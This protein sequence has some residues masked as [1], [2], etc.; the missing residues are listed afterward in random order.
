VEAG[1]ETLI[2][3]VVRPQ[4]IS[5]QALPDGYERALATCS[6]ILLVA[7]LAALA[8]GRAEWNQVPS[9]VWLHLLTIVV[10][11]VLTPVLLLRTRG[12]RRHRQLGWA[13]SISMLATALISFGIRLNNKG[14]LSLI[15][16][17]SALTVVLVPAIV[18]RARRHQVA[19]HRRAVRGAVTGALLVAGF[20]TFPFNRLLGQWLF[21]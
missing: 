3:A 11:L 8:R 21:G 6:V 13:W 9:I 4:P 14:G 18:L 17:L 20:F 2:S 12:D 7:I 15:H 10:A 1:W 5:R 19:K 16:V